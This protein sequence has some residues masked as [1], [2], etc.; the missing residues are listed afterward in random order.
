MPLLSLQSDIKNLVSAF[1]S[2]YFMVEEGRT[3]IVE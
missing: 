2:F 3:L 1:F